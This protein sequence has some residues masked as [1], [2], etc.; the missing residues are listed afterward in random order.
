MAI[1]K[2][3]AVGNGDTFY[4]KHGTDNFTIIDCNLS[5][6]N[7]DQI[8]QELKDQSKDKKSLG[9]SQLTLIKII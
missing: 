8:I 1:V 6:E 3:F 2:S 5:D 9:L 7:K 4:I